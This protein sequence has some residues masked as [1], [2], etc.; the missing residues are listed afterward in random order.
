MDS[1]SLPIAQSDLQGF[2]G[3]CAG[4]ITT[5]GRGGSDLTA[6]V[7]GAALRLEEV[8][9]WKDV[10]GESS[11]IEPCFCC[12][13]SNTSLYRTRMFLLFTCKLGLNA[14]D[15]FTTSWQCSI[16][17]TTEDLCCGHKSMTYI[18][19]VAQKKKSPQCCPVRSADMRSPSG[20]WRASGAAVDV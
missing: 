4:A 17:Q 15:F 20:E 19:T 14:V 16:L 7:I 3:L 6:T 10:D 18:H 11:I 9:V 12:L 8:Q 13:A 5:L 2:S 1:S